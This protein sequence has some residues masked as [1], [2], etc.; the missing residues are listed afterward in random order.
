MGASAENVTSSAGSPASERTAFATA[1]LK[2]SE[3]FSFFTVEPSL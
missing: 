3:G 2:G 1:R